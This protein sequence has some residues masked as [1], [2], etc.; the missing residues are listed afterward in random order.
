MDRLGALIVAS[1]V[2]VLPA[3]IPASPPVT[4][5]Y[6]PNANFDANGHFAPGDAGF[7]LSDV[8]KVQQLALLPDGVLGLVWVGR[9]AGVDAAFIAAVTP[10][11]GHPKVFGFYLMDDPDPV[12]WHG[13]RCAAEHLKAEADWIRARAPAA[14]T[15]IML[16]NLGTS[17]DP[18]FANSYNPGNSH[19]DLFGLSPYPCRTELEVCDFAMIRRYIDAAEAAGIPLEKIVPGYQTFGGG[20]WSDGDGGRYAVPSDVHEKAILASW[21]S[22]IGRPVFDYAYSWG[23]QRGDK[24]LENSPDLRAVFAGHN[25]ANAKVSGH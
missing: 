16:M 5:H 20:S 21:A 13:R 4:R 7:N 12:W 23:S 14:R 19:V 24:A 8:S 10:F 17:K 1:F 15:F 22:V 2:L 25:A 11:L 6:A 18:S 3:P 9:C